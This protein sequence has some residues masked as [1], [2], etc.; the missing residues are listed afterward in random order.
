[1]IRQLKEDEIH[2][3]MDMTQVAFAVTFTEEDIQLRSSRVIPEQ[4]WGYYL[5][6]QLSARVEIIPFE[7]ALQGVVFKMGGI[8][9]V[10]T[11]PELRRNG[12]VGK[13][14]D[15][16]LA[17]MKQNGQTVSM[18]NPFAFG[19][20]RK[21][22]W[23]WFCDLTSYSIDKAHLPRIHDTAGKVRRGGAQ[24]YAAVRELYAIFAKRYNGMILR[25]E[26]W[27]QSSVFKRKL[28]QLA[29]YRNDA[30]EPRGYILYQI[31]NKRF[32]IQEW[33]TLDAES[34]KGL[35]Q[36]I[37]HHDSIVDGVDFSGP[38]N[39]AFALWIAE[40]GKVK[41][42]LYPWFMFRI[43][44]IKPFL[45]R[46]A[47]LN[48]PQGTSLILNIK[49]EH[50][51]WNEGKWKLQW[52]DEGKAAVEKLDLELASQLN[53]STVSCEC[54]IQTLSALMCGFKRP[55]AMYD[56]GRLYGD[57]EAVHLLE[58]LIPSRDTYLLDMF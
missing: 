21:Y 7:I 8:A 16:S 22:G 34:R 58:Q 40:P 37:V 24:D 6:D 44:D 38:M 48:G 19:F 27:W 42:E 33:I 30:G 46:Y 10:A 15:H 9:N 39:D 45:E 51:P 35:W 2:Q 26:E 43:V 28:G 47:F 49:D 31:R 20:Y 41:R 56:L 29:V 1:M 13:L 55:Q 5:D 53:V 52:L 50:A 25:T 18:L 36:Y 23:E 57:L 17:V 11:Y 54:D 14:M 32:H 3:F 4:V 12:M